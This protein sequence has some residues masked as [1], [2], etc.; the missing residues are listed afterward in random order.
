[1]IEQEVLVV[2]EM[3]DQKKTVREIAYHLGRSEKAILNAVRKYNPSTRLAERYIRASALKLAEKVVK[4]ASVEEAIDVL[5]RPN[6]G[7]LQPI[8]SKH[9]V[10]FFTSVDPASLGGVVSNDP[11]PVGSGVSDAAKGNQV[12][13]GPVGS[14]PALPERQEGEAADLTVSCFKF[15]ESPADPGESG[16]GRHGPQQHRRNAPRSRR[17]LHIVDP[18]PPRVAIPRARRN[19][20]ANG[21]SG[22]HLRYD[23]VEP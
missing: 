15:E 21:D 11:I 19:P 5:T 7:V 13:G 20:N 8:V 2:L 10:G 22:I 1:M 6:V 16:T 9:A 17:E 14:R 23:I 12:Q 3:W 4:H 18:H